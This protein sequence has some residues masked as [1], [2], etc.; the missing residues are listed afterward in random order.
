[1]T[2]TMLSIIVP[3][4]MEDSMIDWLLEQQEIDGFNSIPMHGHGSHEDGMSLAE[5]VTGK[6]RKIMFQTHVSEETARKML[7]QLK[8]DFARADIHYMIRPLIDAGN[9][10]SYES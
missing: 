4:A 6:S 8:K 9:L 5:K 2:L 3:V 1:M 10:S 7:T